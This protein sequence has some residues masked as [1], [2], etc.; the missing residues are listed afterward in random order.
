MEGGWVQASLLEGVSPVSVSSGG[1][2]NARREQARTGAAYVPW[3]LRP[4]VRARR[5][6]RTRVTRDPGVARSW[7]L[8]HRLSAEIT[9]QLAQ[10]IGDSRLAE[11][12]ALAG[13]S[14]AV[15]GRTPR[16]S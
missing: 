8:S 12:R 1:V 2:Q 14:P 7:D 4:E 13:R 15:A 16:P 10:A 6:S 5:L 3:L 9:W 11:I